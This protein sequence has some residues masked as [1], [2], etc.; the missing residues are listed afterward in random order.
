M[1]GHLVPFKYYMKIDINNKQKKYKKVDVL[2]KSK[3]FSY[4]KMLINVN[5]NNINWKNELFLFISNIVI[6]DTIN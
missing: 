1:E 6:V 5:K 4:N 2:V 3:L